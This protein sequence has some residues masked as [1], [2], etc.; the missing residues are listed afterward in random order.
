MICAL[1]TATANRQKT[2]S[3]LIRHQCLFQDHKIW[4]DCGSGVTN[5]SVKELFVRTV[6]IKF[7]YGCCSK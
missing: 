7:S 3:K 4:L 5:S 1:L 6:Q 2:V